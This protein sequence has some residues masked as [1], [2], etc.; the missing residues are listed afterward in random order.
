MVEA[1][2]VRNF[3]EFSYGGVDELAWKQKFVN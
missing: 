2:H 3:A 1:A